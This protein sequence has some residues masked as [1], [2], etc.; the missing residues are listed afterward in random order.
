MSGDDSVKSIIYGNC[1]AN[2]YGKFRALCA[3]LT[4]QCTKCDIQNILTK[5]STI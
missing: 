1:I 4:E 3:A 2:S 5:L